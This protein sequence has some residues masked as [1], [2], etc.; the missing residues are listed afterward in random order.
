M[1]FQN[2]SFVISAAAV[3]QCPKR[4]IPHFVFAGKSNVGKSSLLNK[5]LNRKSL[6]KISQTPG[7]TR[8]LNFFLVDDHFF[9]V[10]LPGY[11][12]AKVSQ[13]ERRQW[14]HLIES[15]LQATPYIACI[16]LLVDIRH[17]LSENDETM[18]TWL[19]HFQLPHKVLLT[20]ADKLSR[21][22]A[23][24]MRFKLAKA[25]Q[26]EP[27]DVIPVSAVKGDGIKEVRS[28]IDHIY[29]QVKDC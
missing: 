14:G 23:Q 11:G 28:L 18:L 27:S 5:I 2:A 22:K 19:R 9:F 16:F 24:A 7:K 6:A 15:Y 29:D 25:C 12:F 13:K 21:G 20:K 1:S 3:A 17:S 26:L 10:D 8:L 4:P